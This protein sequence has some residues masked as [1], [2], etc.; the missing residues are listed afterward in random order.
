MNAEH[1][2]LMNQIYQT[3]FALDEAILFL[4]TH[5]CDQ[6]A[7]QYYETMQECYWKLVKEHELRFGPLTAKSV[8]LSDGAPGSCDQCRRNAWS[9][10]NDP[11]PWE[12]GMC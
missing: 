10:V 7:L 3:G 11:W 1:A 4:D 12:G 9:W 5:P 6:E 8:V 2:K